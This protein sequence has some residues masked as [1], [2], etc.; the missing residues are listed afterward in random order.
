MKFQVDK[1]KQKIY[2]KEIYNNS[3]IIRDGHQPNK[4]DFLNNTNSFDG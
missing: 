4:M 1:C 2:P 3:N